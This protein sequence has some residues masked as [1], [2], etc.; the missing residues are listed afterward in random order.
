MARAP[1]RTLDGYIFDDEGH[2]HRWLSEYKRKGSLAE[3]RLERVL[4]Q[5][6]HRCAQC[7]GSGVVISRRKLGD[8][9]VREFLA[10]P[11][12]PLPEPK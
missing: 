3:V 6:P 2:A 11:A 5:P 4:V 8:V 10:A 7:Q 9:S 12:K 1:E